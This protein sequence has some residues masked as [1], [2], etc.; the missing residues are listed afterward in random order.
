MGETTKHIAGRE[1]P[2]PRVPK[3]THRPPPTPRP[4]AIAPGAAGTS[5]SALASPLHH[6]SSPPQS[7]SASPPKTD[8]GGGSGQRG[9]RSP[10]PG[11]LASRTPRADS[12]RA[13]RLPLGEGDD[14]ARVEGSGRRE[15]SGR[16]GS[17]SATSRGG[18][19]LGGR[20]VDRRRRCGGTRRGPKHVRYTEFPRCCIFFQAPGE[21]ARI[22]CDPK[23]TK[24]RRGGLT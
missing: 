17:P 10:R 7:P 24:R 11:S 3:T 5:V 22:S 16:G 18:G 6:L 19:T 23:S 9:P 1:A 8:S 14:T 13:G 4:T 2:K 20:W 15:E 21:N 12:V